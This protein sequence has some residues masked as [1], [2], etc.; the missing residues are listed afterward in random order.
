MQAVESPKIGTMI[1]PVC[2]KY[3]NIQMKKYRSY[4]SH[5]TEE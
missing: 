2:P 3:T 1:G 4:M 5:E